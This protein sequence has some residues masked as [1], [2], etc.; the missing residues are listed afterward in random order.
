MKLKLEKIE[1]LITNLKSYTIST[2]ELVQLEAAQHASSIIAKVA[3]G[4]I[5]WVVIIFF[6]FFLSIGLSFYLSELLDNKYLGFGIVAAAYLLLGLILIIGRRK[7]LMRP[8]RDK[9]IR[10]IFQNK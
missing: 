5:V 3:S 1:E 10:E 7:L 4:L 8:I 2:I 6:A 9:F